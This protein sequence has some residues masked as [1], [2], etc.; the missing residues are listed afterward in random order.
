MGLD[1]LPRE[2]TVEILNNFAEVLSNLEIRSRV[3]SIELSVCLFGSVLF[4]NFQVHL[5]QCRLFTKPDTVS[6]GLIL[7]HIF[8]LSA[9]KL[10]KVFRDDEFLADI[11]GAIDKQLVDFDC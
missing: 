2:F 9:L 4:E 8:V 5:V 7:D 1:S 6:P 11:E 3:L 10:S